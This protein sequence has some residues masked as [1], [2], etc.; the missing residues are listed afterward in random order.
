MSGMDI[1]RHHGIELQNPKAMPFPLYQAVRNQPFS[2]MQPPAF[3]ETAKLALQIWPHR[4]TLFGCRI[5]SP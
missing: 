5:Y 3:E 4:P 2:D 1:I